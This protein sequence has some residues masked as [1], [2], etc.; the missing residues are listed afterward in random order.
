MKIEL[1]FVQSKNQRLAG[2]PKK[3]YVGVE[4]IFKIKDFVKKKKY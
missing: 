3:N 1:S 4:R 2:L